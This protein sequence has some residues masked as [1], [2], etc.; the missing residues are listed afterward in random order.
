MIYMPFHAGFEKT[1][2]KAETI[3]RHGSGFMHGLPAA[4]ALGGVGFLA[5]SRF[6]D[7]FKKDEDKTTKDK[8]IGKAPLLGTLGG[9]VGGHIYG[10][11]R[12]KDLL[13]KLGSL[14][15]DVE[16]RQH[17][18]DL[19]KQM[20]ENNGSIIAAHATGV[21]KTLGGIAAFEDLKEKGK[22]KRALVV[23]PASLRS[24][25]VNSGI[26]KFTNSSVSVYG[27]KGEKGSKDIGHKSTSTYNVVS[28]DLFREHGDK[29]LADTGADTLIMDEVHRA[30]ATDGVTYNKLRDLRPKF[31][32]AITLTGSVV[33][34][35]PNEIVPMLD[36][37]YGSTGHKL[38]SKNFFDKLFV[39]KDVKTTGLFN[40]KNVVE[41]KLKN[42]PQLAKYLAGKVS[43]V[44]HEMVEKLLPKKNE[45]TVRVNMSPEQKKLYDFSLSAVDPMTRW[46][47]RNNIPVGQKEAQDA[48]A[49]IMQAR[50]VSTDPGIMN[51]NLAA[52]P[53]PAVYSP[54][55]KRVVED[56][57]DHLKANKDN[58]SVIYGNLLKG[59]LEGVQKSLKHR[60]IEFSTFYG[61]GNAG[62]SDKA[63]SHNLEQF[64]NGNSRV[65]L[66]SGA[67]AEGLDL[68]KANML[69]M[70]EG[71]YNPERIHQAE[72]RI[73]RM[74]SPLKEIHIK[75]YISV[76][77]EG[78]AS[79]F[80]KGLLAKTPMGGNTGV[81]DWIYTIAKKKQ[82][83]NE[84]FK[85]VLN[86]SSHVK[87]AARFNF[88][89]QNSNNP[90]DNGFGYL[91]MNA[92]M[93]GQAVGG[94]YIARPTVFFMKKKTDATIE[95]KLKQELL[96]RGHESLIGK[97]HYPKILAESKIDEKAIDA[98]LGI[99][100]LTTGAGM[101]MALHPNSTQ[102]VDKYLGM[103]MA[104]TI[105]KLLPTN[106]GGGGR[107]REFLANPIGRRLAAGALSGLVIGA[108]G[109]IIGEYARRGIL[110]GSVSANSPDLTRGIQI[111]KDKLRKAHERKYKGSKSFVNEYE[112]KKELGIDPID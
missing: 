65:L 8:L 21:G 35:D 74:G 29:L 52:M 13:S 5:R 24:N 105:S 99:T 98:N 7:R 57:E 39:Q 92:G 102:F 59:Q 47:I 41:K 96:N 61:V 1:A 51:E 9:Y 69:Q 15:K 60:G 14:N 63:R 26:K 104:N 50:Q 78:K 43:Y 3:A 22:G 16:L 45:E 110:R 10:V 42:K 32:N 48:L 90:F 97:K 109:P 36:L 85:D 49:Q 86:D 94:G 23:V 106:S 19:I 38:V 17:Q 6:E 100:S 40:V 27:P 62:N 12:A 20:H 37:T 79:G 68:K 71:H 80:V 54:K 83:L 44:P 67:G 103:P 64:Q 46:K 81:D 30:R 89:D 82:A 72:S 88:D 112:T 77:A 73:R 91:S 101:L 56:L 75:R 108:A 4:M 111:Y 2:I 93:L 107:L 34:N 76:P 33:N 84:D 70:L 28:Y 95:Q 53:D 66:I 31:K 18:I 25:F 55:I 58:K 87:S 11:R